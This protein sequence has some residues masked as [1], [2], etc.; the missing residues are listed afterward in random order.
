MHLVLTAALL[1]ATM[2][3]TPAALAQANGE[4]NVVDDMQSTTLKVPGA[5]LYYEVRGNGPL[6]VIIPGGPEDAGVFAELAAS[7]S[8]T[9]RVVA[10]DPRGNS[11]SLFDAAPTELDVS[12]LADDVAMLIGELGG[13]EPADIF[14]TSG[15][16]QIGLE[17]ARRD[18]QLVR[19][20]VAHEPPSMMLMAD[21]STAI[22]ETEELYRIYAEQGIEAAM[23]YFF[24]GNNLEADG[25]PDF[26]DMPPET[27]ET[28]ARVSANFDYWLAHGVRPLSYYKPDVVALKANGTKVVVAIGEASQGQPIEAMATALADALGIAPTS[29][30]GDHTSFDDPAF[31]AAL[32]AALK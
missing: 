16:A 7:L 23:G 18:P 11:R 17:L 10:I 26:G 9:R 20:L 1:A 25:P 8:A 30:P 15:G 32:D 29:F 6:L 12:V 2:T 5:S 31:A 27:A 24:G 21:P 13:G 28:M 14:G 4:I 22:A 19:T 3:V